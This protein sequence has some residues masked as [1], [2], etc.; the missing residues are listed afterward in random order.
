MTSSLLLNIRLRNIIICC[1]FTLKSF[2]NV[3]ASILIQGHC[4]CEPSNPSSL[5]SKNQQC[6]DQDEENAMHDTADMSSDHSDSLQREWFRGWTA[7]SVLRHVPRN[8]PLQ[9]RGEHHFRTNWKRNARHLGCD[10]TRELATGPRHAD[11][12]IASSKCCGAQPWL[13]GIVRAI[14]VQLLWTVHLIAV[15]RRAKSER[16]AGD[17]GYK[18]SQGGMVEFYSRDENETLT[19]Y[20]QHSAKLASSR[21]RSLPLSSRVFCGELSLHTV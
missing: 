1:N 17:E 10:S 19:T 8:F 11:V 12:W 9:C 14:A 2:L 3:P 16:W 13:N 4:W 21:E 15:A 6:E 18:T 5:D 20:P 7:A